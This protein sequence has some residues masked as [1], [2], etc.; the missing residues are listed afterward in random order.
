M[1][2]LKSLFEVAVFLLAF[3]SI[4][5]LVNGEP[6]KP[7]LKFNGCKHGVDVTL[8]FHN[9]VDFD[10]QRLEWGPPEFRTTAMYVA[11]PGATFGGM[12]NNR[13]ICTVAEAKALG[14]QQK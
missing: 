3:G 11:W 10:F 13:G 9:T 5:G 14:A 1:R 6:G 2:I 12:K 7:Y 4:L 8:V